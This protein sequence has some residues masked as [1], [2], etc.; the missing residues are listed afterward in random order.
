MVQLS[1][2]PPDFIVSAENNSLSSIF[3]YRRPV[4]VFC[5]AKKSKAEGGN[6]DVLLLHAN[7]QFQYIFSLDFFFF[8]CSCLHYY[9]I[10]LSNSF[11]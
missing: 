7:V 5:D 1:V 9:E 4:L 11:S 6:T 8:M 3:S 10:K 2:D